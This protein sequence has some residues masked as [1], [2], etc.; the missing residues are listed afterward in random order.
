MTFSRPL[1]F[2]N[3]N[4]FAALI[5]PAMRTGAVRELGFVAIGALGDAGFL[6]MIV[7]PS[8]GGA[9]LGVSAFRI[10]HYFP[11]ICSFFH[12][13]F[14]ER[15]PAVVRLLG[16]ASATYQ[17]TVLP[18][19]GADALAIGAANPLHR[20]QSKTCSRKISFNSMPPPS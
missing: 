4:H 7:R 19:H 20:Q 17:I 15:G 2:R 1:F 13:N 9:L 14:L 8:G 5:A 18:A 11:L 6:E 10:G 3:L 12:W 16:F